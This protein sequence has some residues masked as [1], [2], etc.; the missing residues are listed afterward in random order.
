M[1]SDRTIEVK[2][3]LRVPFI[4]GFNALA[5][6]DQIVE[7]DRKG[8]FETFIEMTIQNILEEIAQEKKEFAVKNNALLTKMRELM[9]SLPEAE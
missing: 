9:P 7:D 1:S 6:Y 3:N 5:D 4:E 2:I 8:Y